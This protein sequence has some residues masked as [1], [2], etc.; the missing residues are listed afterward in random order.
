ML[1]TTITMLPSGEVSSV[2]G[3]KSPAAVSAGGNPEG[4]LGRAVVV[5]VLPSA[6]T[7]VEQLLLRHLMN[8][9][10]QDLLVFQRRVESSCG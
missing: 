10:G 8:V 7:T 5:S 6:S 1:V 3:V 9:N 2:P 4:M